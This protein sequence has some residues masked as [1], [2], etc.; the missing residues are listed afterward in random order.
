MPTAGNSQY[1]LFD[2]IL[3]KW[4]YWNENIELNYSELRVF[5]GLAEAKT[6]RCEVHKIRDRKTEESSQK[7]HKTEIKCEFSQAKL[8][9]SC[10]S[11]FDTKQCYYY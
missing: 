6:R 10:N 11:Y 5:N 1:V 4:T 9:C 3:I 8:I 7:V 2:L